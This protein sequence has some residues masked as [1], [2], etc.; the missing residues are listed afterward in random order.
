MSIFF[1]A[2]GG[3]FA[4]ATLGT[5]L[6]GVVGM[7]KGGAFNEKYGNKLMRYRVIFQ[8]LAI[9]CFVLGLLTR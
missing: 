3:L 5:L 6:T 2:L 9:G 8:G 1:F 4:I 7:G